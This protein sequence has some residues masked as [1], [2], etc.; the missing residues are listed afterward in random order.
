M[1]FWNSLAFSL[2]NRRF[3]LIP[4]IV[5]GT[6]QGTY[7]YIV[8]SFTNFL[9]GFSYK[10]GIVLGWQLC[11]WWVMGLA[12]C[13]RNAHIINTRI[14]AIR[15]LWRRQRGKLVAVWPWTR[16][17]PSLSLGF[18]PLEK[19]TNHIY[20]LWGLVVMFEKFSGSVT[21]RSCFMVLVFSYGE[22][23]LQRAL[24]SREAGS[25]ICLE[26]AWETQSLQVCFGTGTTFIWWEP[27]V[28]GGEQKERRLDFGEW[29]CFPYK[30]LYVWRSAALERT[31]MC[32]SRS[33]VSNSSWPHG[34]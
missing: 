31:C 21:P 10:H 9:L 11:V 27:Q 5:L 8:P 2:L 26:V 30:S 6:T 23:H 1:F 33:V 22:V 15:E 28:C 4:G 3:Y 12:G 24:T 16:H 19:G 7:W 34:L 25:T 32:V 18:P 17:F 20:L 29:G 13:E 14:R